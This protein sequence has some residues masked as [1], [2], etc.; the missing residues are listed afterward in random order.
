M[1]QGISA[2]SPT[3]ITEWTVITQNRPAKCNDFINNQMAANTTYNMLLEEINIGV[4]G[5]LR[6]QTNGTPWIILIVMMQEVPIPVADQ[7]MKL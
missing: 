6:L 4:S 7:S 2:H 1:H 3:L 5:V